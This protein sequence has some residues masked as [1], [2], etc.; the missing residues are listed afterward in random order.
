MIVNY[1]SK[2]IITRN[3][4]IVMDYLQKIIDIRCFE[5]ELHSEIEKIEIMDELPKRWTYPDIKPHLIDEAKRR[6]YL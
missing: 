4:Y 3:E 5:T 1:I 2:N 6:G